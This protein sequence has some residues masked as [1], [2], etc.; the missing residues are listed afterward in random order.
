M[1]RAIKIDFTNEIKINQETTALRFYTMT[2]TDSIT[3]NVKLLE[4][5][6]IVEGSNTITYRHE[7]GDIE[8]RPVSDIN[9]FIF[10][11][12]NKISA[13]LL[14]KSFIN[15]NRYKS[16]KVKI[17]HKEFGNTTSSPYE[18]EF[19]TPVVVNDKYVK[20]GGNNYIM[21]S[22]LF[23]QPIVKVQSNL[24]RLFTNFS[25][26]HVELKNT[27]L[28]AKTDFK[29]VEQTL[30]NQLKALGKVKQDE[31]F[32]NKSKD[33]IGSKYGIKDLELFGY[34]RLEISL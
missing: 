10:N 1:A 12:Y 14:S 31:S 16:F 19:R 33:E 5:A 23:P 26:S 13:E 28:N 4:Y 3:K 24:V 15:K 2:D 21:I 27:K 25:I 11:V 17:Q 6:Q 34:K 18:L 29:E 7:T 9:T 30:V 8:Y 32:S 20:L 22:Q